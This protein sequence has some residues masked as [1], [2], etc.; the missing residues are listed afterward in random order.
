MVFEEGDARFADDRIPHSDRDP[1]GSGADVRGHEIGDRSRFLP[2][3]G[4]RGA[5][6]LAIF[7][8]REIGRGGS[9][10]RTRRDPLHPSRSGLRGN[11]LRRLVQ[12]YQQFL[13]SR[14]D[15]D[16]IPE[17]EGLKC[18]LSAETIRTRSQR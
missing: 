10:R 9:F 15:D 12:K 14:R 18:V 7:R 6:E 11:R 8:G 5:G 13:A 2:A 4:E 3:G 17:Q 16:R 1:A